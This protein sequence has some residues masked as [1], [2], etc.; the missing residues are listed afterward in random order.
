MIVGISGHRLPAGP[1]GIA[2]A[3]T[4][5]ETREE[6]VK[7]LVPRRK[8][9][10]ALPCRSRDG[11]A[12]P[13]SQQERPASPPAQANSA[14]FEV[15][16]DRTARTLRTSIGPRVRFRSLS[17][18]STNPTSV[19]SQQSI[20]SPPVLA[21]KPLRIGGKSFV[22]SC[23]RARRRSRKRFIRTHDFLLMRTVIND[24]GYFAAFRSPEVLVK[25]NNFQ[26]VA[27]RRPKSPSL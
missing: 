11:G 6:A 5:P 24:H 25:F 20:L 15:R 1:R 10:K 4:L 27:V 12:I 14:D 18:A 23:R 16:E 17:V 2:S 19:S 9:P 26:E 3:A 8:F 7:T 21:A 13:T 22:H